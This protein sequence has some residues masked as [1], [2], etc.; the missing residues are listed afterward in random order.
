M[1]EGLKMK[2]LVFG[3]NGKTGRLVV[4][5]AIA[6]GHEVTVLVRQMSLSFPASV[7]VIVGD[8]LKVMDIRRAMDSQEAILSTISQNV[9]RYHYLPLLL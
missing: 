8:A 9:E 7:R 3:A 6:A 5:R 4:D 1:K 2:V